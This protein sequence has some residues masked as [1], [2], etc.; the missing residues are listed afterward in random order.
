MRAERLLSLLL[1]LQNRGRLTTRELSDLLEISERTVHRDMEALS[2]AGIPVYAER[3]RGGGWTHTRG[4]RTRLTG[5]TPAEL[6][7]LLT[8]ADKSVLDALGIGGNYVSAARKLK[9]AAAYDM[10]TETTDSRTMIH[11]DG[12]SWSPTYDN[13]PFLTLLREAMERSRKV[14]IVYDGGN[15]KRKERLVGPLGLVAKRGVW[16][17]AAIC[18][19]QY[20]TYRV[21]RICSASITDEAFERPDGFDIQSYWQQSIQEFKDSL[22]KYPSDL[23][24]RK[25][26]IA[27]LQK[28][29]FVQFLTEPVS[30]GQGWFKVSAEF[31]S[32]ESALRIAL[33]YGPDLVVLSP[34]ELRSKVAESVRTVAALYPDC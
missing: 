22:P 19:G 24:I 9:A 12:Q 31:Q 30:T 2:A 4:Y 25:E 26:A 27:L 15:D 5:M 18:E 21:S 6:A 10:G 17:A 29:R 16:Y 20:R 34:A 3:G 8:G 32:L 28:E 13:V 7:A 1:L 14:L 11:I 33:S 23:Q